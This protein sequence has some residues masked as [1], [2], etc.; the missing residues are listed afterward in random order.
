LTDNIAQLIVSK[1]QHIL[2]A[3]VCCWCNSSGW[4]PLLWPGRYSEQFWRVRSRAWP[5]TYTT[6]SWHPSWSGPR[7]QLQTAV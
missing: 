6:Q 3:V 2:I 4:R 7:K 1:I 5:A